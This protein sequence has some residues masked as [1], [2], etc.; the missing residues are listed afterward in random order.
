MQSPGM[1]GPAVNIGVAKIMRAILG[2][3]KNFPSDLLCHSA[4]LFFQFLNFLIGDSVITSSITF[5]RHSH[6]PSCFGC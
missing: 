3:T 1:V 4:A 6:S 2:S 5:F